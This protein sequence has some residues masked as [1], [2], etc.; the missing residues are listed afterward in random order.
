MVRTRHLLHILVSCSTNQ[1]IASRYCNDLAQTC[2][3]LQ[4]P[5]ISKSVLILLQVEFV[6]SVE[7]CNTFCKL[8][9]FLSFC[10]NQK[11]F[12]TTL[13]RV[14]KLVI[15]CGMALEGGQTTGGDHTLKVCKHFSSSKKPW[16]KFL[17]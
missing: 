7:V 6:T 8:F 2:Q 17:C 10:S 11:H 12:K 4:F 13:V 3:T 14:L 9:R 5:V 16:G 15:I 1:A